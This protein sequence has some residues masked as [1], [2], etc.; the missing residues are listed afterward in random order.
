MDYIKDVDL[1]RSMVDQFIGYTNSAFGKV[2]YV[3]PAALLSKTPGYWS[4]NPSPFGTYQPE[5]V[6]HII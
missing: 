5:W 6:K 1:D 3:Q 2:S 4:I